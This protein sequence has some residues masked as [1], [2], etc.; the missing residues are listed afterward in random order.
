MAIETWTD[1]CIPAL[2][3]FLNHP[4]IVHIH[5]PC[6]LRTVNSRLS[7]TSISAS[8]TRT[9]APLLAPPMHPGQVIHRSRC[10]ESPNPRMP[11][12]VK[13]CC[14][15][16]RM[17]PTKCSKAPERGL[18]HTLPGAPV[19]AQPATSSRARRPPSPLVSSPSATSLSE[20]V[21]MCAPLSGKVVPTP[22][23]GRKTGRHPKR[24]WKDGGRSSGSPL[25]RAFAGLK[26]LLIAPSPALWAYC[27]DSYL[28]R[29]VADGCPMQ[30]RQPGSPSCTHV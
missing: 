29:R 7:V 21:P 14:R 9:L 4:T 28:R 22:L 27:I 19:G 17:E 13:C 26:P 6:Q 12:R 5:Q 2:L 23:I 1:S 25:T 24:T 8:R 11:R 30:D 18:P 10:S 15:G 3:L 16:D 20:V